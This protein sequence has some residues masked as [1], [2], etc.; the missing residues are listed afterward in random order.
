MKILA[1]V[2][3]IALRYIFSRLKTPVADG[4]F[5]QSCLILVIVFTFSLSKPHGASSIHPYQSAELASQYP[6]PLS[7]SALVSYGNVPVT[8][9]SV[10]PKLHSNDLHQADISHRVLLGQTRESSS[11]ADPAEYERV[12]RKVHAG[13]S[14]RLVNVESLSEVKWIAYVIYHLMRQ[15]PIVL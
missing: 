14:S 6:D 5:I 7:R 9:V 10:E 8:H 4:F 12:D 15:S 11:S 2:C 1:D 3:G 13:A